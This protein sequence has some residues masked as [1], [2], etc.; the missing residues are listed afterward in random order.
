MTFTAFYCSSDQVDLGTNA[1]IKGPF[2]LTADP[3]GNVLMAD[4]AYGCIRAFNPNTTVVTTFATGAVN[5]SSIAPDGLGGYLVADMASSSSVVRRYAGTGG[6]PVATV[7]STLRCTLSLRPGPVHRPP[8]P[9]TSVRSLATG[10]ED[11]L[12][13]VGLRR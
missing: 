7:R 3:I 8:L 4:Y 12:E 13:M 5:P 2:A 9:P 6:T 1:R 11:F 10:L